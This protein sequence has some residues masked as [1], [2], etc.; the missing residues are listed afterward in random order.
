MV[1]GFGTDQRTST[2]V[3]QQRVSNSIQ[4]TNERAGGVMSYAGSKPSG[5]PLINYYIGLRSSCQPPRSRLFS[6]RPGGQRGVRV[7]PAPRDSSRQHR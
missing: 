3:D 5:P 1:V 7:E 2:A 6:Q 4:T